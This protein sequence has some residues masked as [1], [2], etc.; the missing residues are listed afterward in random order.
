MI[1]K[2]ISYR[3]NAGIVRVLYLRGVISMELLFD[4]DEYTIIV[5][6]LNG[7]PVF[8][9][10]HYNNIQVIRRHSLR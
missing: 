8:I 10:K 4:F 7:M 1:L 5:I 6:T 9:V 2:T 3:V